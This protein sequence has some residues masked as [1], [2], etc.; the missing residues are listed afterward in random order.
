VAEQLDWKK[1]KDFLFQVS[2]DIGAAMFGALNYMGDRLGIFKALAEAGS[3][4]SA[5]LAVKTGLNERYLREWLSAMSAATYIDYD[6]T[7]KKYSMTPEHALV[8]AKEESPF[9]MGGFLEMILPNVSVTPKVMEAFKHG[10]GVKQSEYAPE[11]WEAMERSSANIYRHS[12]VRKWLPTLPEVVTKLTDGGSYLDV[13]CGSG[14]AALSVATAFPKAKVSGF[15]AFQG[16]VD[17]AIANAKTVGLGDRVTFKAQDCTALPKAEF[18]FITTF[19]VVHDSV[20]PVGLMRSI[21]SALKPGGTYLMVE[22]NTSSNLEDNINPMGR[23][24]YSIST[25]YCMTVSL[26]H[27]GAGIGA[28]MGEG[29]ARDLAKEAGFT[30]FNRLPVDDAFSI[31]YELKP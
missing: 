31:L 8:L 5:E 29:K 25:L 26:A 22:V 20:D 2:G 23:M 7:T 1:A 28:C 16:S 6:P 11:T 12:F 30:H 18:D 14:R 21:R 10:G 13:G 9:F 15:D 24:M 19:D 4:T 3:V 27:N 17:R